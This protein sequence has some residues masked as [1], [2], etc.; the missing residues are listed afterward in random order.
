[1]RELYAERRLALIDAARRELKGLVELDDLP[2]GLHTNGWFQWNI[3]DLKV[4]EAA[5]AAGRRN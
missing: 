5:L 3:S 1:M 2:A 4:V